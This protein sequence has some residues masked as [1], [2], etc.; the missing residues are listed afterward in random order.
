MAKSGARIAGI[1][2]HHMVCMF[3][4]GIAG[5][6]VAVGLDEGEAVVVIVISVVGAREL[7]VAIAELLGAVVD[8]LSVLLAEGENSSPGVVTEVLVAGFVD[9]E[10][11]VVMAAV[12]LATISE[13][14]VS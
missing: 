14:L 5:I 12:G 7:D 4:G 6:V 13:V 1:G 8:K 10:L 11:V 2:T 9:C 3:I